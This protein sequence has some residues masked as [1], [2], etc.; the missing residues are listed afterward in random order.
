MFEVV[1]KCS[2]V[3]ENVRV[4]SETPDEISACMTSGI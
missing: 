1:L 3:L 2:N 4:R